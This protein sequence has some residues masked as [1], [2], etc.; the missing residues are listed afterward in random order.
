MNP[1][2]VLA[3]YVATED[4]DWGPAVIRAIVVKAMK[5]VDP[6]TQTQRIADLPVDP[7]LRPA[8][9]GNAWKSKRRKDHVDLRRTLAGI[10]LQT[11]PHAFVAWHVDADCTWSARRSCTN[12]AQLDEIVLG[13]LTRLL[14]IEAEKRELDATVLMSK[15][16][17]VMPHWCI[18]S[19]LYQGLSEVP[20]GCRV[21]CSCAELIGSW[22]A[23]RALLDEVAYPKKQLCVG[24]AMNTSLATSFPAEEVRDAGGSFASLVEHMGRCEPLIDALHRSWNDW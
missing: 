21:P 24:D 15:L 5:L 2:P 13:P 20:N 9:Q 1:A 12:R 14:A 7:R 23:D 19:W 16:W 11:R 10:L 22:Q 18:E 17:V 3:L 6:H 8:F 4:G